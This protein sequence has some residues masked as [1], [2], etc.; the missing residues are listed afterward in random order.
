MK[1]NMTDPIPTTEVA[2]LTQAAAEAALRSAGLALG[3]VTKAE[4]QLVPAGR[5]SSTN[6]RAD[7]LVNQASKVDL[8]IST[9]RADWTQ[10]AIPI[11]FIV[12][13]MF[14]LD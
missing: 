8:E 6:P 12:L 1:I 5:V 13:G 10:Q 3:T 14:C 2:G 7:T 11:A 4:N 9:T